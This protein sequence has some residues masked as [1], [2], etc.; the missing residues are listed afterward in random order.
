MDAGSLIFHVSAFTTATC[1]D[2]FTTLTDELFEATESVA[3][4]I[5]TDSFEDVMAGDPCNIS[6]DII[7]TNG[8]GKLQYSIVHN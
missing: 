6:I 4:S 8:K 5:L 1:E 2:L 3:I 7:N